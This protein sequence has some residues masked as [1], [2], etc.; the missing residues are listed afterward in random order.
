MPA[1]AA[2]IEKAAPAPGEDAELEARHS[3]AAH[4][5]SIIEITLSAANALSECE[6]SLADRAGQV[7][8]MLGDL[9]KFDPE[10]FID[11]IL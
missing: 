10:E 9:E 7:R 5:K 4:S 1:R 11:S 3:I 2:E 6:D 8:R